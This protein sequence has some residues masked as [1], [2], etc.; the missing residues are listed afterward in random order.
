M[1]Y[2]TAASVPNN[3]LVVQVT[4]YKSALDFRLPPRCGSNQEP[5]ESVLVTL[6]F[7]VIVIA[8]L[9]FRGLLF[10]HSSISLRPG[11]RHRRSAR[12]RERS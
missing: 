2:I 5:Y 9:F 4:R 10:A 7:V 11:C 6:I 3:V 8:S 1:I 12:E